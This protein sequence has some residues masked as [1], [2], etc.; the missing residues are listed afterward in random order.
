MIL[1]FEKEK[2]I[3]KNNATLPSPYTREQLIG[4][5]RD[6][7]LAGDHTSSSSLLWIVLYLSKYTDVQEKMQREIDQAMGSN[8]LNMSLRDL[9]P[10]TQA[11]IHVS[12]SVFSKSNRRFFLLCILN[13]F[14][15]GKILIEHLPTN[16]YSPTLCL[17]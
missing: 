5:A 8:V 12:K 9:L 16:F 3:N 17:I 10:Y 1:L 14:N 4:S 13:I 2:P 7:F 15:R 11:V 6:L